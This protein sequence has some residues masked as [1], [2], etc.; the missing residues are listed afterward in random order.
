MNFDDLENTYH[1]EKLKNKTKKVDGGKKGKR[2]EREIVG[3]LNNRFSHLK[4]KTFSRSV[5]SGNRW[6][7]VKNLPKHA[8]DTLTGDICCPEGFNFVIESKGGYNKIDLN[9]I[10]ESGNTELDNFLKQV[11]D[12]S[13][14][15]GKMP[16]LFW[17][18]DRRPWIAF[19][20]TQDIQGEYE[21]KI[22]YREWT[23]VPVKELLKLSDSFFFTHSPEA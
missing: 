6:A 2:V 9:S 11:S 23:C 7:Q 14:R 17:K 16:L 12:D 18:K 3:I 10:F 21:Y 19:L 8:K 20:R 15:C 5:G 13:K 22:N 4:E 1:V